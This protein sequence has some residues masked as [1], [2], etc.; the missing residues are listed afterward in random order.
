MKFI[1]EVIL[2]ID[3]L[4]AFAGIAWVTALD[5]EAGD[6]SVKDGVGV[7]A[8]EAVLEEGAGSE[9]GLLGEEFEGE[10]AGGGVEKEFRGGWRF[11]V[12]ERGHCG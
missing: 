10:G 8:I 4:S 7:V 3:A 11:E 12:V 6:E 1:L 5:D 2:R 9:R